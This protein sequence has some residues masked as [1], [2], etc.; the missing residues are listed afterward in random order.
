M[1][2]I[3]VTV[4]ILLLSFANVVFAGEGEKFIREYE[5]AQ[6]ADF[7]L[8]HDLDPYQVEEYYKYSW[9]PYPLFRT[10]IDLYFKSVH[11]VPGYYILT[12]RVVK[13][14]PYVF[15]KQN[16]KVAYIVPVCEIYVK[17]RR[18][19]YKIFRKGKKQ[20]PP[21]SYLEASTV[22]NEFFRIDLYFGTQRYTMYFKKTPERNWN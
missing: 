6:L 11:I 8:V 2:K 1:K 12:P 10:S 9:S 14:K 5:N 7:E 20:D 15:F 21:K 17:S 18:T 3:F 4:V 13:D 16:G 22:D 19:F